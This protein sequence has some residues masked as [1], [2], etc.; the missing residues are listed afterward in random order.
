M[1]RNKR[2]NQI[3]LPFKNFTHFYPLSKG[4]L[5]VN[6]NT[7][8]SILALLFVIIG[9]Y[10]CS[11]TQEK[12][13]I[14]TRPNILL[15]VADDLGYADLGCYGGDIATPNIDGLASSGIR[16]SRFHTAPMCAPTRAMLL[17]GND[18]HIA[19]IGRQA[20]STQVFGYEGYLTKRVATIPQLLRDDGYHTYMAGK[21]HLGNGKEF[22]PHQKGFENSFVLLEGVGNHYNKQGLFKGIPIS[23]YT[24]NGDPAEWPEGKYSTDLYTDKLISF[25]DR[26]KED[27]RP[28]FAYAAYTSP[29]WPLQVDEVY[30]KKYRG[31]YDK[32]Y[33]KLKEE[34]LESLK[35]AG[36][37]PENAVLPPTHPSV[38]PWESLSDKEK[39]RESRKMELYA[40]MVD[41]LDVNIGRLV[42]YLKDIGAYEN[43]LIIFMSDNGAAG[44]DYYNNPDIKPYINPY[45][46]NDYETMG[47]ANSLISYG[48]QWAEA[49]SSPFRYYKEYATNGGI[50]AS[51][52]ISGP[53]V[54]QQNVISN[55]FLTVMDIAPTLYD[56][57]EINYP[58]ELNGNSLFPMKG[59]SFLPFIHG[60]TKTIHN[61]SYV[62]VL[63]HSGNT[64][65]RKGAWKITNF[66]DPFSLSEFELYNLDEDL[67]E[68]YDLKSTYPDKY[69]ELYQEW[70]NFASEIKVQLP[71]INYD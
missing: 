55:N 42:D 28:F 13:T 38:R 4:R 56:L 64:M 7:T 66:S 39:K 70:T 41:N 22:N 57:A 67:G 1:N 32:G 47:E 20:L 11:G 46:N 61:K 17:T 36:M 63:E 16:F 30:W 51:M 59:Q 23:H 69:Q 45:F 12:T 6:L 31:K 3:N 44:E 29:H 54:E 19:G 33:D 21:W 27:K 71:G 68:M 37:I 52:I 2:T 26:H 34:R 35:K 49:G 53:G 9:F 50:I 18:N 65:L 14:D 62:F 8:R 48:P 5:I 43:T 40:G 10:G 15:L 58:R 60:E 25:I 24:E